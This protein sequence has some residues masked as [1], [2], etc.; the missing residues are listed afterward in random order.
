MS[1]EQ[2]IWKS[3]QGKLNKTHLLIFL[4]VGILLLVISIPTEEKQIKADENTE[5][6]KRLEA[7][8][9]RMNGVGEAQVM[10]TLKEDDSVEGIAVVAQGGDNAVIVCNI[11]EVVQAL[12]DVDSHKIKIVKMISQ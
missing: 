7:I 4:L 10:I 2:P 8:L 3:L 12:F 11:T 5:L 9:E 6:E 1:E